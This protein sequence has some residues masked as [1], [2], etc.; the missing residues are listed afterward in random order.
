MNGK[1]ILALLVFACSGYAADVRLVWDPPAEAGAAGYKL[2]RG[3]ASHGY[4]SVTDVGNATSFTVTGLA[5]GTYYFAVTAYDAARVESGYSNEVVFQVAGGDTAPPVIS[6][7]SVSGITSSAAAISWTTNE[8]ATSQVDYGATTAYG[9]SAA[10]DGA[11]PTSHSIAL[12]G[13]LPDALYHFRVRSADASGNAALS[14][15]YTFTTA[16]APGPD[17]SPPVISGGGGD[18]ANELAAAYAF[19]EGR[20]GLAVDTSGDGR[21]ATLEGASWTGQGKFGNALLL[22]GSGYA[23]ADAAGLPGTADPKTIAC[24]VHLPEPTGST[25]SIVSLGDPDA[26]A[27]V[28]LSYRNFEIGV[29]RYDDSWVVFGPA[30]DTRGWHHLAYVFDGTTS[31]LYI[32]GTLVS[33]STIPLAAAAPAAFLLGRS[34][35]GN[36]PYSGAIDDLRIYRRPLDESEIAAPIDPSN[37]ID[38]YQNPTSG[39]SRPVVTQSTRYE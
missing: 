38:I 33:S 17:P 24:W 14:A 8:P 3:T 35:D 21:I 37:L 27:M 30:P 39:V 2:Y 13:L 12:S 18:A 36:Q 31:T 1:L 5:A 25:Q 10:V 22:D 32:D 26:S 7:V 6:S 28:Q 34:V 29:T 16:A 9:F 19:D 11:L 15:D 4:D 20:G 23:W